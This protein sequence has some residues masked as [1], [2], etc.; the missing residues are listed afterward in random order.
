MLTSFTQHFYNA[1]FEVDAIVVETYKFGQTHARRIKREHDGIS[2]QF[3][4][5]VAYGYIIQQTIY[6]RFAQKLG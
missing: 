6:L 5:A 2:Q 4:I 1:C 3:A